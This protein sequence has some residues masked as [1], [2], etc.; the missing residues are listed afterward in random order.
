[1][2]NLKGAI[3]VSNYLFTLAFVYFALTTVSL[4]RETVPNIGKSTAR[5]PKA[6]L[7]AIA[8]AAKKS[9]VQ[10]CL[11]KVNLVTN[12]LTTGSTQSGASLFVPQHMANTSMV[13]VSL[14]IKGVQSLSYASAD[15]APLPAG[16][17]VSYEAVTYWQNGCTDVAVKGFGQF[18]VT[19]TLSGNIMVLESGSQ[20]RVFLMPAGLGCVSIKKE[21]VYQ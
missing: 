8:Q 2:G 9:G 5:A 15:F 7:N 4:A 10:G 19:G 16:C 11:G 6:S 21:I 1:M 17:N 20:L 18:K 13:S 12:F 14:E 3:L